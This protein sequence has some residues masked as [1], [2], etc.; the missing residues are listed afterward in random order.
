MD[1]GRAV[2]LHE[3]GII[4]PVNRI[5]PAEMRTLSLTTRSDS[6]WDDDYHGNAYQAYVVEFGASVGDRQQALYQS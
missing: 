6:Q 5:T 1:H 4:P 2:H 3:L